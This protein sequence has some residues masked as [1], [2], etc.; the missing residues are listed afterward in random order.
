[1]FTDLAKNLVGHDSKKKYRKNKCDKKCDNSESSC[2]LTTLGTYCDAN[3]FELSKANLPYEKCQNFPKL[4]KKFIETVGLCN[5][6]KIAE[7]I[8]TGGAGGRA[9]AIDQQYLIIENFN[10]KGFTYNIRLTL[11]KTDGKVIYDSSSGTT[12]VTAAALPLHTTRMEIQRA[13]ER[14][15]GAMKR[16][17]STTGE[18]SVYASIWIPNILLLSEVTDLAINTEVINFRFAYQV[19]QL[20]NPVPNS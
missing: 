2:A 4:I 14:E 11:T 9:A 10:Y 15:W 13:T 3:D 12:D 16:S 8:P 5:L 1:M 17:S 7:T 19:D 6:I 20:G 18:T